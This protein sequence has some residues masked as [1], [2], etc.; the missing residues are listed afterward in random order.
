M[1]IHKLRALSC[2]NQNDTEIL[3]EASLLKPINWCPDIDYLLVAK[4]TSYQ[5]LPNSWVKLTSD[6]MKELYR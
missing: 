6:I 3:P 4:I 1:N 2:Q 5:R